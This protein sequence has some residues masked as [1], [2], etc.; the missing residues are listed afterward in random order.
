MNALIF[1]AEPTIDRARIT[2]IAAPRIVET[3][4]VH[5]SIDGAGIIVDAIERLVRTLAGAAAIERAG[6]AVVARFL[7]ARTPDRIH[8]GRARRIGTLV[9][10]IGDG[11]TVAVDVTVV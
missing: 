7:I 9:H 10:T 1:E 8:E 6:V 5:A 4:T 3:R 11:V 2:V